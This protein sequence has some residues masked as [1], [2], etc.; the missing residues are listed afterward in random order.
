MTPRTPFSQEQH[1]SQ[2]FPTI[3][4]FARNIAM[5]KH[6]SKEFSRFFRNL[7]ATTRPLVY[8]TNALTIAPS[9]LSLLSNCCYDY[10]F[11]IDFNSKYFKFTAVAGKRFEIYDSSVFA[12]L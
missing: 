7:G 5:P 9:G 10:L 3:T 2:G 4:S 8:E 1:G 6:R 11:G 12:M